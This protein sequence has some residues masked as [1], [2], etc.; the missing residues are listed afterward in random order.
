M[1][2]TKSISRMPQHLAQNRKMEPTIRFER[3]TCSLRDPG[4]DEENQSVARSARQI[5]AGS[6][7][8]RR[9]ERHS[10][11]FNDTA[12]TDIYTDLTENLSDFVDPRRSLTRWHRPRRCGERG[13]KFRFPERL[14][15]GF[16]AK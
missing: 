16:T 3:T 15:R 7:T 14:D 12:T 9:V 13:L 4:D 10:S 2:A 1:S 5:A 6:G 11:F 8:Q